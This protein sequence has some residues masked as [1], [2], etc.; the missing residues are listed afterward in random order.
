MQI[1]ALHKPVS[2][3]HESESANAID[4]CLSVYRKREDQTMKR[5][6]KEAENQSMM[7]VGACVSVPYQSQ[8]SDW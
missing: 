2:L 8:I 4:V 5:K 3:A 6:I 1:L 7:S